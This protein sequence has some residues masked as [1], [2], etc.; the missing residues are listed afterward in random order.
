MHFEE[1]GHTINTKHMGLVSIH[2]VGS[3]CIVAV[4]TAATL[5]NFET[6]Y[7]ISVEQSH[8]FGIYSCHFLYKTTSKLNI[9]NERIIQTS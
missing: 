6:L 5:F 1:K 9:H 7:Y 8:K 4:R 2:S 3:S